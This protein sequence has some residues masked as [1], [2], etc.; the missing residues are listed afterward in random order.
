[1]AEARKR[2]QGSLA[3]VGTGIEVV[4]H[5]TTQAEHLIAQADKVLY[6][7]PGPWADE[8]M[9]GLNS[10][11]ESLVSL[12]GDAKPRLESYGEIVAAVMG[13]VRQGKAVCAVFYG[14]PGVFVLPA[15]A[16]IKRA[17]AEGFEARMCAGVSAVDCLFADVGID[18]AV[19]GCQS[20]E[21]TD[22]LIYHRRFDPYSAL[23]LW[24]IGLIGH[25][26]GRARPDNVGLTLLAEVLTETY[27][28]EHE[29]IVYEA[30]QHPHH[31]PR[32]DPLPLAQLPQARTLAISTLY[33]PPRGEK[34]V[35]VARLA[36]L[37]LTPQDL[38]KRWE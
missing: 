27:G 24:Q 35:D 19:A 5:L 10:L 14:H 7:I 17:R 30:A 16:L 31:R 37:G 6:V 22:F 28:G 33:V 8:W 12:Y 26:G 29:V 15:H 3:V 25:T 13:E 21:A 36:R 18:P 32:I 11:A 23:I 2:G 9:R 20:F 38:V 1:M 34:M 4:S